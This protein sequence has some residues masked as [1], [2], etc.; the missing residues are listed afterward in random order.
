M[1]IKKLWK[2]DNKLNLKIISD[3]KSIYFK[4][5]KITRMIDILKF[6]KK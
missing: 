3:F 4:H 1:N 6:F 5:L 2:A